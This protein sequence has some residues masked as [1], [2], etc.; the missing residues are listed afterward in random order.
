MDIIK[1]VR[2]IFPIPKDWEKDED[3]KQFSIRL[4]KMIRELFS[5]RVAGVKVGSDLLKPDKNDVVSLGNAATR[6]VANNLTTTASGR[7]LDARQGKALADMWF[8]SI[9]ANSNLNDF[10]EPGLYGCGNAATAASLSN[11]PISDGG[12]PMLV[13]GKSASYCSQLLFSANAI[14]TRTRA[15]SGWGRWYKYTGTQV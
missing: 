14:F 12:F 1:K 7:V 3:R 9:S 4:D 8:T 11:C 10:T 6:T 2:S 15:S 5:K 13:A